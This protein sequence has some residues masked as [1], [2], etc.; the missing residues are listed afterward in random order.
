MRGFEAKRLHSQRNKTAAKKSL[1]V[2][3][4]M[5]INSGKEYEY[6]RNVVGYMSRVILLN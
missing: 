2:F 1:G 5:S 4:V 6:D 3:C